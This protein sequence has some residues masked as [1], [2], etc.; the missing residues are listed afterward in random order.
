M[1]PRG[2]IVLLNSG[3]P[4][5]LLAGVLLAHP[6]DVVS[7]YLD[8]GQ[9]AS[10]REQQCARHVADFLRASH[11]ESKVPLYENLSSKVPMVKGGRGSRADQPISEYVPFRNTLFLS[12]A[13]A[14]AETI[15]ANAVAIGSIG[16]PWVTPDNRP[17]YFRAMQ[18]TVNQGTGAK[19]TIDVLVP[20]QQF[21]K[22]EVIAKAL[23]LQLP[24]E[25]TWSCHNTNDYPCKVCGNCQMRH[26]AFVA[27]NAIDPLLI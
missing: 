17:E 26:D 7:L 23:A 20:L 5:A 8:Y 10:I 3:G 25:K 11:Y 24:L 6:Y 4:D 12:H 16:G 21:S 27:N 1:S 14:V 22:S 19:S 2:Q 13:V 9:H 18:Q 15:G